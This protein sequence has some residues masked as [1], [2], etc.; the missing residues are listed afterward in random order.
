MKN[1]LF[2]IIP[3]RDAGI[4]KKREWIILSTTGMTE[5]D[6]AIV[7][8]TKSFVIPIESALKAMFK[9]EISAR[10]GKENQKR[11]ENHIKQLA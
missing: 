11:S 10:R 1:S 7:S 2:S 9:I 5:G 3:A 8:N 6:G 4:Q